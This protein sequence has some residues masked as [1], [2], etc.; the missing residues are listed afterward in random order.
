MTQSH[1]PC[2]RCGKERKIVKTWKEKLGNSIIINT[3]SICPDPEC[4]KKVD[5]EN[6]KYRER[7]AAMKLKSEQRV[8]SRKA[9]ADA[10]RAEKHSRAAR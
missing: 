2:I 10:L 9:V 7:Q 8:T 4:Q 3:E 6:K 5:S 1:N